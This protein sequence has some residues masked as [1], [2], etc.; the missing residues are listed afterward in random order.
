MAFLSLSLNIEAQYYTQSW[1][2][3]GA[4][5]NQGIID[6]VFVEKNYKCFK[7]VFKIF[8]LCAMYGICVCSSWPE[9]E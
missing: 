7:N 9:Y 2:Q 6:M 5:Y 4:T 8:T 3:S 1:T